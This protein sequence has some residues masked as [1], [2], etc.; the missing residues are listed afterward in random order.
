MTMRGFLRGPRWLRSYEASWLPHDAVAGVTLAAYAI[1]VSLAYATLAGLPPERGLYGY[2]V[3]GLCYALLGT[4][5]QLAVGPTS[6]ISMLVGATVAGM[7]QGDAGRWAAIAAL[8][9]L[10]FAALCF[11]AWLLRLSALV[12]F[13]GETILLG[14]KAGAAITIAMTQMPK[15]FGVKGGGEHLFERVAAL[16]GQLP[17]TNFAVLGFGLAAILVLAAGQK[18]LPGKPV[19]LGVVAASIAILSLT[20]LRDHGFKVVGDLPRGLP[21]FAPPSLR[22]RDVDGIVP[23]AFACFLL[24]YIESVS[25]AR[26]LAQKNGY[27]IDA[28][29]EL[30]GLAAAN[31]GVAFSQGFPVAG[32]L[33]QSSVNDRAGA[34]TPLALVFASAAIAGCLYATGLVRNLPNVVLASIVLVAVS[35]LV[36]VRGL[37]RLRRSSRLEFRIAIAA[38]VGVLLLGILKGVVLA[39]VLS[40]LMLIARAAR[41]H[42]AFLGRIPGTDRYSGLERNPDNEVIPGA[43]LF[44]VES[45]IFYFNADHVLERISRRVRG[46]EPKPRLVV[47]D[48]SMSP[49]VDVSGARMLARLHGDLAAASIEMRLVGAHGAVR[50]MLR[51]EGLEERVGDVSRRISLDDVVRDFLAGQ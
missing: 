17:D 18:A 43:L 5:R 28:R 37:A 50:D 22:A 27:E 11:L 14:F 4:S 19:A 46:A 10:V 1:P 49:H 39:A 12:S 3:G 44:R 30:L 6:A 45:G 20:A 25:A 48:L 31:L 32:G 35:G 40:L 47:G 26:T 29:Q 24:A 21:D 15:L 16:W 33:S 9:A 8:T 23:L 51:V 2:M 13:I 38:L 41:P 42:V 36:D 34:R 7:A